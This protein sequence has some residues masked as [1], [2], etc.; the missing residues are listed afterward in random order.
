MEKYVC[1]IC[2]HTYDPSMGEPGQGIP[3]GT[4]FDQL[5]PGWECP[6]CSAAKKLFRKA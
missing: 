6:V 3:E 1:M 4:A 2:G 5:A